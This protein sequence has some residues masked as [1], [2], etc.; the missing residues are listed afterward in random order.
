MVTAATVTYL[1]DILP[2][3]PFVQFHWSWWGGGLGGVGFVAMRT[4]GN[5]SHDLIF[6]N[7]VNFAPAPGSSYCSALFP[8]QIFPQSACEQEPACQACL[9]LLTPLLLF[10]VIFLQPQHLAYISPFLFLFFLASQK[11]GLIKAANSTLESH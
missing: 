9:P 11:C 4:K 3:P 5:S 2:T 6:R 7:P 1:F 8:S 10:Y